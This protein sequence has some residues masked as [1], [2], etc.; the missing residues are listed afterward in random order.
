MSL[1]MADMEDVDADSPP[2]G[3]SSVSGAS[4]ALSDSSDDAADLLQSDDEEL[5]VE[6]F[7]AD[8]QETADTTAHQHYEEGKDQQGIPWERLQVGGLAWVC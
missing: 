1:T 2:L 8:E 7:P 6:D 4:P 3:S 5:P